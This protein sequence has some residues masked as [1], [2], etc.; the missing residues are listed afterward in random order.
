MIRQIKIWLNEY[1]EKLDGEIIFNP[2]FLNKVLLLSPITVSKRKNIVTMYVVNPS[3]DV[4]NALNI[5]IYTGNIVAY[6]IK[7]AHRRDV[8]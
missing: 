8:K 6:R 4:F 5:M 3:Q 1:P 2:W 7:T